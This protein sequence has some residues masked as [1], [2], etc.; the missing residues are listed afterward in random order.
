[1]ASGVHAHKPR[2]LGQKSVGYAN[3]A[4]DVFTGGNQIATQE[5]WGWWAWWAYDVDKS[6][7]GPYATEAEAWACS[8]GDRPAWAKAA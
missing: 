3:V 4:L 8:F 1:M 2:K 6:L 7:Q 5:R